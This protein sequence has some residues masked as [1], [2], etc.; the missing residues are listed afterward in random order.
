MQVA[1]SPS[2][3][4]ASAAHWAWKKQQ[5]LRGGEKQCVLETGELCS[6]GS[7]WAMEDLALRDPN[8]PS[9]ME[10]RI[11]LGQLFVY[12]CALIFVPVIKSIQTN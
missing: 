4:G 3:K 7:C 11:P 10:G 5:E 2:T 6:F 9:C 8:S 1:P 12:S